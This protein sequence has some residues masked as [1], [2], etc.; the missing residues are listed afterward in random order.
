MQPIS[1]AP[2]DPLVV[3]LVATERTT[4]SRLILDDEPV[5]ILPLQSPPAHPFFAP[6]FGTLA[7]KHE[8][9]RQAIECWLSICDDRFGVGEFIGHAPNLFLFCRC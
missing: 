7:A 8:R 6:A 9:M 2:D 3:A 1:P 5:A 4:Q